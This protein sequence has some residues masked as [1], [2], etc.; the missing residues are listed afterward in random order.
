[1]EKRAKAAEKSPHGVTGVSLA[2]INSFSDAVFAVA[3]TL[4]VLNI[5]LPYVR[6]HA[7]NADLARA[8]SSIWPHFLAYVI[9]FLVIGNLWIGHHRF[10]DHLVRHDEVLVWLNILYLLCIVFI[11]FSTNVLS[12]HTRTQLAVVFYAGTL[13]VT[14]LMALLSMWY[15]W[16]GRRLIGDEVAEE[17]GRVGMYITAATALVFLISIGLSFISISVAMYSWLALIPLIAIGVR[18]YFR[19]GRG[20]RAEQ[21]VEEH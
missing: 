10:C 11:P 19:K 3:I 13:V 2:R 16:S 17:Y 12:L 5:T 1:M 4:L 7:T 8:M 15:A 9:S 21:P 20:I 14:N 6:P 18:Y